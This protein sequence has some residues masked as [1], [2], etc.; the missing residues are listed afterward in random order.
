MSK[1]ERVRALPWA[2]LLQAGA[3]AHKR[4]HTLSRK[5]RERVSTLLRR[6][7]GRLSNLSTRERTELRKL[8]G[9]FDLKASTRDLMSLTRSHRKSRGRR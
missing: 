6:S 3:L 4:W 5:D 2:A 1:L 8:L 9:K 7:H